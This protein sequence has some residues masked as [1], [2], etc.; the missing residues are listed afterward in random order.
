MGRKK[1]LICTCLLAIII[2]ALW[3]GSC[4]IKNAEGKSLYDFLCAT[5]F[6]IMASW[7]AG[8]RIARFY[9]WLKTEDNKNNE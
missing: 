4:F 1:A 6:P 5:A 9:E 8:G 7:Y 2:S 3:I